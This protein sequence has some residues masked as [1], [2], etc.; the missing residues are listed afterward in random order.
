MNKRLKDFLLTYFFSENE[1]WGIG[2]G[3]F[4]KKGWN[5][6]NSHCD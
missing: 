3:G 1:E 4:C 5:I 2:V 6:L